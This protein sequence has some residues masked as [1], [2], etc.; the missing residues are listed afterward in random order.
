MAYC[1]ITD[2]I[3]VIP[4][5]ILIQLC[6]DEDAGNLTIDSSEVTDKVDEAIAK[7][8]GRIEANANRELYTIPFS[9]VPIQIK[10]MSVNITRFLL[11]ERRRAGEIPKNIQQMFDLAIKDLK[12]L[13]Q[14]E[15]SLGI[16]STPT[17][18]AYVKTNKTAN[19][20]YFGSNADVQAGNS[21]KLNLDNYGM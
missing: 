11:W 17:E 2:I 21:F 7:A 19:D 16:E 8:D 4:E 14:G 5:D 12:L 18:G 13:N 20:K 15:L 9:P 10:E 3:K 1:T 6:D